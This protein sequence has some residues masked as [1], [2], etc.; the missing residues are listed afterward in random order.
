MKDI[1][2]RVQ[3]TA[4]GVWRM[5]AEARK[6]WRMGDR[7]GVIGRRVSLREREGGEGRARTRTKGVITTDVYMLTRTVRG[8]V[9]EV[10]I[11]G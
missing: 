3:V 8:V 1:C 11:M 2:A 5:A 6:R 10:E 9:A 7:E 4:Y